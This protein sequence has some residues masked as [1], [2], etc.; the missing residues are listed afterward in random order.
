MTVAAQICF[1]RTLYSQSAASVTVGNTA[2]AVRQRG[3]KVV[4]SL[5]S[6]GDHRNVQRLLAQA[7]ED[8]VLVLKPNFQD[9][10]E[11]LWLADGIADTSRYRAVFLMGVYAGGNADDLMAALP[12]VDGVVLGEP[13]TVVP[14]LLAE[15][16]ERSDWRER[17]LPGVLTR[18]VCGDLV[19]GSGAIPS[20]DL[21][22]GLRPARDVEATERAR[23]A[24]LEA[25]RGCL[26]AC[27]FCHVPVVDREATAPARRVKTP[28]QV[29][30]E[31]DEL[32]AMG[33][34]Y[35]VFN[36]PVFWFGRGDTER[37]REIARLLAERP[38]NFMVYLRTRP[39]PDDKLLAELADA[40]LVR[41]FVGIESSSS[42]MLK[43]Y[44]K[45][46]DRGGYA[47]VRQKLER[48]GISHHIGF[49][50][51]NPFS[52]L[53]QV[54]HDLEYLGRYRQ[55]HRIGV[56][57][58]RA[59]LTPGTKMREDARLAGLFHGTRDALSMD[60]A[61]S[62]SFQDSRVGALHKMLDRLFRVDFGGRQKYVEYYH[63]STQF[64]RYLVERENA[65][66]VDPTWWYPLEKLHD[67]LSWL[68]ASFYAD[69]LRRIGT[70]NLPA[71]AS[72]DEVVA[73]ARLGDVPVRF[74]RDLK[75]LERRTEVASAML[76]D[77]VARSGFGHV[78]ESLFTSSEGCG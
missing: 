16:D 14:A 49:L 66:A 56:V 46:A 58:E 73:A 39:F 9:A 21:A 70:V 37:V 48:N 28:T 11:S 69:L 43:L 36:D 76:T 27:T 18:T 67:E 8:A 32:V 41:V 25:S 15:I 50:V 38:V 59:R 20:F 33:K 75:G 5:L 10:A 35:V 31:V 63:T 64:V 13:E 68:L 62:W 19:R 61:Y 60:A 29:V 2:A 55:L 71:A 30:D 12:H 1:Y 23:L 4:L 78:I 26:A 24:N 52:R 40:G 6:K 7:P 77:Q 3:R 54:R 45:G 65:E 34:R 44:R 57:L 72:V 42:D 17:P 47:V 53:E 51:F 22:S 74:L